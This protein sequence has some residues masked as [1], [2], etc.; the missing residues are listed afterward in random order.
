MS[1]TSD[2]PGG[3][4]VAGVLLAAGLGSRFGGGKLAVPVAAAGGFTAPM[5]VI[6]LR[7]LAAALPAPL[8]VVRAGDPLVPAYRDEGARIVV[9]ERAAR[10]MGASLAA[11]VAALPEGSGVVVALADMPWIA[12]GTIRRVADAVARG[13]AIAAPA[14][15]GRRGHPV[16]FAARFRRELA[17]LDGDLGARGLLA[18][19]REAIVLIDVDDPGVLRDVDTPADLAPD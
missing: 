3:S 10:G 2:S 18:A 16:G 5:A 6:A 4:A 19:Q 15:R 11:G 13:A 1:G 12:A 14:F 17:A 8:V 9:A 7:S